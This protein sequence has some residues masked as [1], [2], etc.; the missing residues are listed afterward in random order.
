M[1]WE[2][3]L[4]QGPPLARLVLAVKTRL[5]ERLAGFE[6]RL[7]IAEDPAPAAACARVLAPAG[8][9]VRQLRRAFELVDHGEPR[10]PALV[11]FDLERQAR[12]P[13]RFEFRVHHH[14]P[15]LDELARRVD[16]DQLSIDDWSAH[17]DLLHARPGQN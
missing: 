4:A 6:Q 10:G 15:R 12:E 9:H 17:A 11:L 5:V 8:E 2:T 14:P 7:Q 16:L 13:L 3:L 1:V